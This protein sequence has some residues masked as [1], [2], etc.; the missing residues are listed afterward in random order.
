MSPLLLA[1]SLASSDG[2][3]PCLR[4]F[5][6]GRRRFT[7]RAARRRRRP[8]AT[9]ADRLRIRAALFGPSAQ[10]RPR[11][12]EARGT[13]HHPDCLKIRGTYAREVGRPPPPPPDIRQYRRRRR[14]RIV[15]VVAGRRWLAPSRRS[16]LGPRSI[17]ELQAKPMGQFNSP[18]R[19][20]P[21]KLPLLARI[22]SAR[23]WRACALLLLLLSSSS[24]QT[25]RRPRL[26][27]AAA[28]D[29]GRLGRTAAGLLLLIARRARRS[30]GLH[31]GGG[32][33]AS[34]GRARRSAT[35][36]RPT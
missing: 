33:A 21:E 20:L 17:R 11:R 2:V 19:A 30:S 3:L 16:A 22:T 34:V 24:R 35:R 26:A 25:W 4:G 31:F 9:Q 14:R 12:E 32:G 27:A 36:R 10:A 18:C 6:A 23:D 1:E 28:K 15:V 5:V 29:K 13:K 8:E 7:A